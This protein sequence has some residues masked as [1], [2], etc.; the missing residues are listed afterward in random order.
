LAQDSISITRRR[1]V[2]EAMQDHVLV[3]NQTS[4]LTSFEVALEVGSDFADIFTV[5]SHDFALGDPLGAPPL[6]PLVEPRFDEENNQFLLEDPEEG[7]RTQVI[8]SRTGRIDG[9]RVVFEV[10]LEPRQRWQ[11]NVGVVP[12]L[13]G[14]VGKPR[15]AER[16]FGEE[17]VH[18][19]DSLTAWQL[20]VPQLKA[21]WDPLERTVGQSVG[22]LA[23]LRIRS[24][25]NSGLG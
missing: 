9:P 11:V 1:F 25:R 7:A 15:V 17:L 19:R 18:I 3:Q 6:P 24:D 23:A 22:D 13:D 5:K 14:D 16:R 10:E 12:V 8:L 4:E 21:S 20:R 2:G